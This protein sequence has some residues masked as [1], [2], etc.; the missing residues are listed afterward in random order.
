M[1][2][3]HAGVG[4]EHFTTNVLGALHV[5]E[6]QRRCEM[7]HSIAAMFPRAKSAGLPKS[8]TRN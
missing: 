7:R 2:F 6:L 1:A 5:A 4:S 8:Q 3:C